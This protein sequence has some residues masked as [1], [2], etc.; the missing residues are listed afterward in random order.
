MKRKFLTVALII[1]FCGWALYVARAPILEKTGGLLVLDQSP[2]PCDAAVVLY[3]GVEYYPRLAEAA[4]LYRNGLAR[5]IVINGNRKTPFLRELERQSYDPSCVW[6][7]NPLRVLDIFG[8]PRQ[9]V[10]CVNAED[11]YDTV[12]EAK[13]VGKVLLDRGMKSVIVTTSKFHT[14]R[15]HYIWKEMY[16]DKLNLFSVAAKKDP[17]NAKSWWKDGEQVRWVLSE[18]GGW[19]YYLW[20]RLGGKPVGRGE[21]T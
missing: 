19:I 5:Q 17:F 2:I 12:T 6:Y 7:E 10:I 8:V 4:S 11:A 3:T 21:L 13:V 1:L 16:G 18:Y 15:A 9:A 14:R 20:K